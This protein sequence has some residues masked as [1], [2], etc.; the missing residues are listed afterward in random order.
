MPTTLLTPLLSPPSFGQSEAERHDSSVH[1]PDFTIPPILYSFLLFLILLGKCRNNE[2]ELSYFMTLQMCGLIIATETA[3]CQHHRNEWLFAAAFPSTFALS[4]SRIQEMNNSNKG[5][6]AVFCW[7]S[8]LVNH[9]HLNT[10]WYHI[11]FSKSPGIMAELET[12][13]WT[14]M[15]RQTRSLKISSLPPPAPV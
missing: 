8:D 15:R 10:G 1:V 4:F 14:Q 9:Q 12:Q 3:F 2:N 13:Q 11:S 7:G 5:K 6:K